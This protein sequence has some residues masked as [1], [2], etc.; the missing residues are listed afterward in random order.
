MAT[1]C[2]DW[3]GV[4]LVDFMPA[5][6]T[7]KSWQILKKYRR[8]IQ[9]HKKGKLNKSLSILNYKARSHV[10]NF[11]WNTIDHPYYSTNLTRSDYHLFP[12]F[13]EHLVGRLFCSDEEVI[14][15]VQRFMNIMA[16]KWYDMSIQKL[17]LN[18][19]KC[20]EKKAIK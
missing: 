6:V 11:G 10:A 15:E 9:N 13:K 17:P 16:A 2:L 14:D 1:I 12:K 8:T 7:K 3:K 18:I 4:L 19:Q 20:I 5:G